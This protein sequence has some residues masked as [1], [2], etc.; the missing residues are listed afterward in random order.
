L[1]ARKTVLSLLADVVFHK[2]YMAHI[3]E[4]GILD[5]H[6][7]ENLK[8]YILLVFCIVFVLLCQYL[9]EYAD[10]T[11]IIIKVKDFISEIVI[12]VA[13]TVN[14]CYSVPH[15]QDYK[16]CYCGVMARFQFGG[17]W[18][19]EVDTMKCMAILTLCTCD[20]PVCSI[21]P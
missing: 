14:F 4:D 21:V 2:T 18:S 12:I 19:I 20:L 17:G 8:S 1:P 9:Y 13:G 6:C 11:V 16:F 7:C 10:T 15:S 3:P 5:S